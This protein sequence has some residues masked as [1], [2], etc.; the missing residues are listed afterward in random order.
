MS[1]GFG[2]V[3]PCSVTFGANQFVRTYRSKEA[4]KKAWEAYFNAYH[5]CI[6]AAFIVGIVAIDVANRFRPITWFTASTVLMAFSTAKFLLGSDLYVKDKGSPTVFSGMSVAILAAIKKW[7]FRLPERTDDG[8]YHHL[9]GNKLSVPTN[10]LRY[11][12]LC[13]NN[14]KKNST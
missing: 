5:T 8:V 14:P 3:R 10:N 6:G 9:S 12:S 1:T 7:R 13:I 11:V 4:R 2:C